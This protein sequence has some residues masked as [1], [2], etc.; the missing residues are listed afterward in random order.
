MSLTLAL[1]ILGGLVLAALVAAPF[2]PLL[3][4]YRG[5]FFGML[6]LAVCMVLFSLIGKLYTWTGGTELTAGAL[7]GDS[8]AAFGKGD[9]YG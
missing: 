4:R 9:V 1:A 6:N 8:V 5:I 2:A 7:Q 3:S